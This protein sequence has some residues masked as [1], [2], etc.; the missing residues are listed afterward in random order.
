MT[1]KKKKLTKR[2]TLKLKYKAE[3]KVR[4]HHKKLKKE[5]KKHPE[6]FRKGKDPGVPKELP[7]YNKVVEE[8]VAAKEAREKRIEEAKM[9]RLAKKDQILAKKRNIGNINELILTASERGEKYEAEKA[10]ASNKDILTDRSAKAYY[11]EFKKVVEA[12]DVVLEVLDA[13][14]PLGT[15]VPQME[16]TI[17]S[18]GKK[19]VLV[20]NKAD[21]VPRDNLEAWLKYLRREHPTVVFKSST[22]LQAANLS[23]VIGRVTKSTIDLVQSSRCVGAD[24][25]MQ[26]LKNYCRNKDVKMA[27]TVGVV[28]IPNVGKS[29][30]INSM[31]R[32]KSCGVGATPGFTKSVQPIQLD[33]KIKLLDCPGIVLPGGDVSDASAALRNAVKVEDLDDPC[34]PV[35]AILARASKSQLMIYYRIPDFNNTDEFLARLARRLG[36]IKRGG[37]PD[38]E[39]T[40]RKV[41]HDWNCGLIKYYTEPPVVKNTEI[42]AS[43]VT[44]LAKEFDIESLKTQE[45]SVLTSLPQY[46][47][48]Q[49]MVVESLGPVMEVKD[50]DNEVES[51]GS[52]EDEQQEEAE[53]SGEEEAE[54]MDSGDDE[55]QEEA[56]VLLPKDI[57]INM[58]ETTKTSKSKEVE[59]KKKRWET[60]LK[61]FDPQTMSLNKFQ[62]MM[63]KK[64]RKEGNRNVKRTDD[65]TA[66]F[67]SMPGLEDKDEDYK[68]EDYF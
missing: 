47:P 29:S 11:R 28:G 30:L 59:E 51:M 19:L 5:K 42:G 61:E 18:G 16:S 65:L 48:S 36:K 37:I 12:A 25:L 39:S 38:K 66:A 3:R 52:G 32:T 26:L 57:R 67:E 15:R 50:R 33:S 13:R 55:Q 20:L 9:R 46:K 53:D 14:D 45:G 49:A 54:S 56:A 35:E 40:A 58:D 8:A 43:L 23:Q 62:K 21:L 68:F 31:K 64:A 44:E 34:K 17:T 41:L 60:P 7:F 4:D 1:L 10:L 63:Q 22:Q 24:V 6:K 27:I 2:V